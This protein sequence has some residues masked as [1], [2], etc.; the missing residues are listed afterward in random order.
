MAMTSMN[1]CARVEDVYPRA[2]QRVYAKY[3]SNGDD[4]D[5]DSQ[6]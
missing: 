6:W 3:V 4:G 5:D 1:A 2:D